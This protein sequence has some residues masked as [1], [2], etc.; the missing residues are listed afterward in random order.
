MGLSTGLSPSLARSS[1][2]F[3]HNSAYL[4]MAALMVEHLKVLMVEQLKFLSLMVE[5][6]YA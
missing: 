3:I 5:P 1:N 4:S 6:A 2:L